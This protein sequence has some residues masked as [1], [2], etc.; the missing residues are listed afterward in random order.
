[1]HG[2]T[3]AFPT[4][5]MGRPITSAFS[6]ATGQARRDALMQLLGYMAAMAD[7][8]ET[9][10]LIACPRLEHSATYQ[11]RFG[12]RPIAEPRQYHGVKFATRLLAVRRSELKERVR[13]AKP[14]RL[15]WGLALTKLMASP[16][17]L[18]MS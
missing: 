14:I 2:Q 9:E 8:Y 17:S 10:W 15:A 18:R 12:F 7:S 11:R 1:M 13:E 6:S 4:A 16:P 3:N 5:S